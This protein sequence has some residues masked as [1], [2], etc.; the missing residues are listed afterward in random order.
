MLPL[1]LGH[2]LLGKIIEESIL[3]STCLLAVEAHYVHLADSLVVCACRFGALCISRSLLV[4]KRSI[5]CALRKENEK[6]EVLARLH[7]PLD[8]AVKSTLKRFVTHT[9]CLRLV[10]NAVPGT[11]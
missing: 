6:S 3:C 9:L 5:R 10:G 1:L 4:C 2:I 11:F 8:P 7:K